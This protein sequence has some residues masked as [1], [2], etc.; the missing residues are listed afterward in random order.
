VRSIFESEHRNADLNIKRNQSSD[1]AG[2]C[3]IASRAIKL[4]DSEPLS[5]GKLKMFELCLRFFFNRNIES[6]S[7][8]ITLSTEPV[9]RSSS[10]LSHRIQHGEPSK[11]PSSQLGN[12]HN[13]RNGILNSNGVAKGVSHCVLDATRG[14]S[15]SGCHDEC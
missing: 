10:S 11:K 14:L 6:P 12:E 4:V 15:P 2:G 5:S 13:E 8:K 3:R 7:G 1:S 9:L